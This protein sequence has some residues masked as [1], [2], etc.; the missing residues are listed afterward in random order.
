MSNSSKHKQRYNPHFNQ[1]SDDEFGKLL[2]Q[3]SATLLTDVVVKGLVV[4]VTK[5]IVIVDVGLKDEGR[6]P[7]SEFELDKGSKIPE[8]G[9]Y[10]DVYVEKSDTRSGRIV[11]SRE[12]A[13]RQESWKD[14]EVALADNILVDGIIFGRVKGGF[15]VDLSGVVAFLPGS[16]LDIRPIKDPSALKGIMQSFQIL[17]M[18]NKL[19]NIVVSRKAVIENSMTDAREEMLSN[20]KE[21]EVLEGIVKNIT[22]YGVFVDL[23]NIDGLLHVTDISWR[24]VNHP[25][26]ILE[27]GQKVNVKIIKFDEKTRRISLGMKQIDA[28]PWEDIVESFAAGTMMSGKITN[29]TDYGAFVELKNGIEGLIHSSEISWTKVNNSPRKCLTIGQEVKF[30]I[31]EIDQEKQ[32]ISLSIKQ[33]SNNPWEE[34]AKTHPIGTILTAPVKH[35]TDFG[36]FVSLNADIDGLIHESDLSADANNNN[37]L[38][39]SYKK[40]DEM[41]CIVLTIDLEKERINLGVK[42]IDEGSSTDEVDNENSA[43]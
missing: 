27:I 24:R 43:E 13:I 26:E 32:R 19:G 35:I 25:S 37:N 8:V 28:S 15:A 29:I 5:D 39:K 9:E 21:G 22:D 18:D 3:H 23:G 7:M 38:L 30:K 33:C 1:D 2:E 16:Q 40:G 14:L 31:L 12:K 11:I 20:I 34:F 36:L 10:V 17:K 6:I 4:S 41:T 42:Q